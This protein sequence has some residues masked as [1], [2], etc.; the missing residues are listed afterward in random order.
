MKVLKYRKDLRCS[1]VEAAANQSRE[2]MR[3]VLCNSA[4]PLTPIPKPPTFPATLNW[5]HKTL[6]GALTGAVSFSLL[7]SSPSSI[8]LD[9]AS[10]PPSPSSH[11]SA[12]DYCRQD[13]DTEAMSETAP[14]LVTNEAIVEE[15]WNIVND[16]FLDS[17]RRRWSSDIWKVNLSLPLSLPLFFNVPFYQITL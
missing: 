6:V 13:D 16:S 8:A 15:A 10:V 17:S 3:V 2:E 5:P 4:S 9:S 11:S 7:I 14:E 12:T 1:R